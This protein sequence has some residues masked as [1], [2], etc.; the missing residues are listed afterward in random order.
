MSPVELTAFR[1]YLTLLARQQL[2][3][4][5]LTGL[6]DDDLV[7]E[8]FN[9]ALQSLDQFRGENSRELAVWLRTIMTN[10]LRDKL[11][12]EKRVYDEQMLQFDVEQ[13]SIRLDQWLTCGELTPRRRA[14]RDEAFLRLAN[15][16]VLLPT[17]QR[18]A[19][20][21]R[22]FQGLGIKRIAETMDRTTSSVGGLLQRGLSALR[23]RMAE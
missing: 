20:E 3:S 8:T 11:R 17:D 5:T 4:L 19:I 16:L 7:Q 21:L 18:Y 1:G 13:S 22:Y 15:A 2:R 12:R 9:R 23:E 6:D 10:I 14:L